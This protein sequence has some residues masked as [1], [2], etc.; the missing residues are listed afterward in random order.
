M[1]AGD[2]A[3]VRADREGRAVHRAGRDLLQQAGAVVPRARA[4]PG[5]QDDQ[6]LLLRGQEVI[7][8]HHPDTARL[9]TDHLQ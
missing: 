1:R 6:D 9:Q 2:V 4:R 8:L 5:H 3:G 7:P